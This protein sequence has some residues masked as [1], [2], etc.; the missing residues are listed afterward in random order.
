MQSAQERQFR[1]VLARVSRGIKGASAD[2]MRQLGVHIG[3]NFLLEEL[4]REDDLTLGELARRMG[5]EV[6]TVTRMTK[7][8]EAAGLLARTTD[9]RDRR[10]VRI[11]LTDQGHALREKL[12]AVLDDVARRALR[13][14]TPDQRDQLIKLLSHVADNMTE[15]AP[16]PETAP[17]ASRTQP[18]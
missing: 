18:D 13:D 15:P 4:W 2:G 14:L 11:T 7:R 1:D 16:Q 12:P 17:A 6:P 10:V 9:T 3:Q 8:M 5:V